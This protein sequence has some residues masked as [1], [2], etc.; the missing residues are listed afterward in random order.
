MACKDRRLWNISGGFNLLWHLHGLRVVRCDVSV[1]Y[2]GTTEQIG[3]IMSSAEEIYHYVSQSIERL[4]RQ[5][6]LANKFYED[7]DA[8]LEEMKWI[9]AELIDLIDEE[10]KAEEDNIPCSLYYITNAEMSLVKIGISNNVTNRIKNMQTSTGYY[11]ELLKEIKFDSREEAMEAERFLHSEYG[12]MRRKPHKITK[13][14]EWFDIKIV[15]SLMSN[16]DTCE[17]IKKAIKESE[18]EKM[19]VMQSIRINIGDD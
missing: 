6:E 15:P 10:K 12:H 16:F 14:S 7:A 19:R 13:T 11:L 8:N 3:G 1:E 9:R 5:K 18:E 17:K 2:L 4:K